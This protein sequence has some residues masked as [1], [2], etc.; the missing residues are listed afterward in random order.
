MD[1]NYYEGNEGRLIFT[2]WDPHGVGISWRIKRAITHVETPYQVIDLYETEDSGRLLVHDG[3]VMLTTADEA[4]YHEMIVHVPMLTHPNPRRV[5]V[6]GGGDGG[7]LRELVRHPT[8]E[9]ARQVEIDG[10]VVRV[11]REHL[12][13]L[14]T[15]FDHPKVDLVIGDGVKAVEEAEPGSYD[16]ILVD[17]TDPLGPAV[18]LFEEPFYRSVHRALAEDGLLAQQVASTFYHLELYVTI[19][20]R[21][22]GIFPLV[23]PFTSQIPA[24]PS[25]NWG[26]ALASKGPDPLRGL[27]AERC[28]PIE[29]DARYWNREIHRAA[30]ALPNHARRELEA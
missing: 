7:T 29:Q 4:A 16:V 23:R 21:L 25:G 5:L 30:F 19:V 2:E 15:A 17:S 24:Y 12:A 14:A 1:P 11:A 13:G 28:E 6:V 18:P 27:E 9:L 3:A 10:E 26:F 20:R 22:R 8:L